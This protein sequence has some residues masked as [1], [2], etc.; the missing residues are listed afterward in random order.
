MRLS[1]RRYPTPEP[2]FVAIS[3]EHRG[4]A[5]VKSMVDP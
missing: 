5:A 1:N 3:T 2:R 4:S